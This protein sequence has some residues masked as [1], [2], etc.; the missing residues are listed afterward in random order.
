MS[1]FAFCDEPF[2]CEIISLMSNLPEPPGV[3]S[4]KAGTIFIFA[5][6]STSVPAWYLV[7]VRDLMNLC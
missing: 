5:N 7:H 6:H 2:I 3:N 1:P 4:M